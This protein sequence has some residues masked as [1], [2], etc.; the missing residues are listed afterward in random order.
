MKVI[1]AEADH[2]KVLRWPC[3]MLYLLPI[4]NGYISVWKSPLA[5]P[6]HN[7][8]KTP[9]LRQDYIWKCPEREVFCKYSMVRLVSQKE[10]WWCF[11]RKL[12]LLPKHRQW[13]KQL[14]A[15][16][17]ALGRRWK[18]RPKAARRKVACKKK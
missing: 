3:L 8:N 9:N 12:F 1:R 10:M 18:N 13:K 16:Q 7:T 15:L 2:K 5:P 11:R 6:P 4:V 17:A 14:P